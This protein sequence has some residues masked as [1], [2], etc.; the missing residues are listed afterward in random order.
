MKIEERLLI[1]Y[2]K[3]A[4]F[5]EYQSE[6]A[7]EHMDGCNL[8]KLWKL[9][10]NHSLCPLVSSVY[11]DKL[12]I[13]GDLKKFFVGEIYKAMCEDEKKSYE[14]QKLCDCFVK[15]K[16]NHIPL[17]GLIIKKMYPH[18]WQRTSCDI[19]I[20]VKKEDLNNVIRI[21]TDE[22]EYIEEKKA[23]HDVS[24]TSPS[25]ITV[26]IHHKLFESYVFENK[27]IPDVWESAYMSEENQGTYFL[28]DDMFSADKILINSLLSLLIFFLILMKDFSS[29]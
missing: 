14:F 4:F 23:D 16:I 7:L 22:L 17:K 25:G 6:F 28:S 19:D 15:N 12:N 10:A 29:S 26:E 2:I 18:T 13:D 27:N 24:L 9:S 8:E 21:L 5:D 1:E 11:V 20:L 3:L